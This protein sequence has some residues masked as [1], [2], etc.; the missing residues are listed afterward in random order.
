MRKIKRK[1]KKKILVFLGL[2]LLVIAGCFGVG[3]YLYNQE[4]IKIAQEKALLKKIKNHYNE[5]V[6]VKKETT[7]YAEKDGKYESVGTIGEGE[8]VSLEETQI[9]TNTKYFKMKELGY[10]D[11]VIEYLEA[12]K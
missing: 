8:V 10:F 4:Q 7:L 2:F 1:V 11:S 6:K 12:L 5:I 9:T 3:Y